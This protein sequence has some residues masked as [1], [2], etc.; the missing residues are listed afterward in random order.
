[1]SCQRLKPGRD[2]F[3]EESGVFPLLGSI[4]LFSKPLEKAESAAVVG[5]SHAF[6]HLWDSHARDARVGPCRSDC[7]IGLHF[8]S[9]SLPLSHRPTYSLSL[10]LFLPS[11]SP[12]AHHHQ[13]P[14]PQLPMP[15]RVL[16]S[17][18]RLSPVKPFG[19]WPLQELVWLGGQTAGTLA[20]RLVLPG[21]SL[22]LS[23]LLF[24]RRHRPP[25]FSAP[26]SKRR[27]PPSRASQPTYRRPDILTP[28]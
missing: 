13:R 24:A 16:L 26:C 3:D 27:R 25:S 21:S 9:I 11:P 2:P 20:E 4:R 15:I 1:V 17:P 10:W 6:S 23:L 18:A 14:V 28:F 5:V 7:A 12:Q 22:L 8:F 19:L